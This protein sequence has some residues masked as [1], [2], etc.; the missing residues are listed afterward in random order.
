[1]DMDGISSPQI[2]LIS[3]GPVVPDG[4]GIAYQV[5]RHSLSFNV[6]CLKENPEKTFEL[7]A[8]KM[9]YYLREAGDHMADVWSAQEPL[10]AKL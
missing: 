3:R 9:Q 1:M 2:R 7:N 4:Y 6:T 8:A 5:N 10:K